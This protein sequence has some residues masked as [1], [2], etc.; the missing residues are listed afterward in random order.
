[1][2]DILNIKCPSCK[3]NLSFESTTQKVHCNSCGQIYEPS[4]FK[5]LDVN[6]E[7]DKSHAENKEIADDF[8]LYMC[9]SCGAELLTDD[10]T[11]IT[12]CP[13]CDSQIVFTERVSKQLKPDFIIPFTLNKQKAVESLSNHF[14]NKFLLPKVFKDEN[15][16]DEIKGI[17]AP[18]WIF[19]YD[20][21]A[22]SDYE[23]TKIRKYITGDYEYTETSFYDV[24]LHSNSSFRNVPADGSSRLDDDLMESIEP[25]DFSKSTDYNSIYL[26]GYMANRYDVDSNEVQNIVKERTTNS[27]KSAFEDK[28]SYYA[29]R[30]LKNLNIITKS[31]DVKYALLPVWILN[32][33][34]KNEKFIFAMNGQTGKFVGNLPYDRK[35]LV[36]LFLISFVIC[37]AIALAFIYFFKLF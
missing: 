3:G 34:W 5:D 28:L 2:S 20:L 19:N 17:Y 30:R 23:T 15:H 27:I 16:I 18:Y 13:Y 22:S 14:K 36:F 1:M 6:L 21:E 8:N 7:T 11:I 31:E 9:N 24:D 25:F 32:T 37:F 4:E 29:T 12:K 35:K 10:D 33:T 26:T